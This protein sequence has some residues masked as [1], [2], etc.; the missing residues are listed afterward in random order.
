GRGGAAGQEGAHTRAGD[1]NLG[2]GKARSEKGLFLPSLSGIIAVRAPSSPPRLRLLW[3]TGTGGGPP[4][5]AAGL[6]W[7]IGQDGKLYGLDPDT[8]RIRRQ[9]TIGVPANHFPTPGIGADLLLAACADRVVALP[10]SGQ[11]PPH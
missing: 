1:G 7:T 6:V 5:L 2:G 8:G 9:T 11:G 3:R 4:I 10:A